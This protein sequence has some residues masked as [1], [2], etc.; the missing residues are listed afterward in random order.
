[1][2]RAVPMVHL[3][4]Q[5]PSRDG[6]AVTRA[7]A[8]HGL[9]HLIDIAHGTSAGVNRGAGARDVLARF[10][11]LRN[12]SRRI[13]GA[14]N[15]PIVDAAGALTAP[16]VEDFDLEWR[17]IQ[18]GLAP[19]AERVDAAV[20][21]LNSARDTAARRRRALEQGSRLRA[22]GLDSARCSR[23]RFALIRFGYVARDQ[24]PAIAELISPLPFALIDLEATAARP[25]V[26]LAA[27]ASARDQID[28]LLRVNGFEPVPAGAAESDEDEASLRREIEQADRQERTSLETLAGLKEEFGEI[29]KALTA[30][31]E[32]GILLL[33]AQTCFATAGRFLVISGWIPGDRA[34]ELTAAVA[35]V[36]GGRAV[37]T[38]EQP[39]AL[40]AARSTLKVP[41][42]Y[43]NPILLRPFQRLVEVYGVP[44]YSE[45]QPT[46]F[47]AVSFLLMFGLMFGDVGHGL[48]LLA[49]GYL[50]FRYAPRFLDY[51]I[52][53][54]EAGA[55][56]TAF[57][58]LHGSV[59]G[60]ETLL[61]AIW[62]HPI[63]DL[64]KFMAVAIGLGVVLVSG[65]IVLNV[66]NS[67]RGGERASALVGTRGLLGAF[68]YWTT[69]AISAR[70][71]LPSTWIVPDAVMFGLLVGVA[72]LLVS[73]PFVVRALGV[74]QGQ[75]QASGATPRWLGALEGSIELVDS[76]FAYFANT[77]SFV[78]V[79]AFAAVHAAV[80]IA[81]F[82]L[83]DTLA[84]FRF[85]G[86]LSAFALVAGNVLM[87][88]LEGLTVTV[89]VLR[90]EYYEFFGKF[91]RGGGEAYRPLMLQ[92]NGA[93]GGE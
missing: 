50:L 12:V 61:P 48:V 22:A 89:Q 81:M 19:I 9:L 3:Q 53:L 36:T 64:P 42:L 45:I 47:F 68:I 35:R 67:W 54:M 58:V 4:V 73:R 40:A 91:F 11:D 72:A 71:V 10:L 79:A 49:A 31:I 62:L 16:E 84:R 32:L 38:V 24:L 25:L 23:L 44:S 86:S 26:A 60:V 92:P 8:A 17:Q 66:M 33:Q 55:A 57:G 75:R 13:A 83:A 6:A 52:L 20:R 39:E 70:F 21:E 59:F 30:R 15:V 76:V 65:G 5:V 1:M 29:L 46:A 63:H 80:F 69:L 88:L 77:I 74:E 90:L 37:V 85:G 56:S 28:A 18:D 41:I 78:R 43:R 34:P 27:A 87:I 2:F 14:L 93:Q 51:A 7:I 82:A